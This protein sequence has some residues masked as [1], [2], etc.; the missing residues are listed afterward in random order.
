VK[1]H[2]LEESP[3]FETDMRALTI[4]LAFCL[5]L[6]CGCGSLIRGGTQEIRIDSYPQGA[7]GEVDGMSIQ[8]PAKLMLSRNEAHTVVLRKEG[9]TEYRTEINKEFSWPPFLTDLIFWKL[10]RSKEL[11]AGAWRLTPETINASLEIEEASMEDLLQ[12]ARILIIQSDDD[13]PAAG[14]PGAAPP[15]LFPAVFRVAEPTE[16][17]TA[18]DIAHQSLG[19]LYQGATIVVLESKGNWYRQSCTQFADGW[20][21]KSVV[22]PR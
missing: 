12:R 5:C 13:V 10:F 18:P 11:S 4:P 3:D 6:A 1:P 15:L 22:R 16:V 9:Y 2:V 7:S 21:L 19:T 8:T 14:S 17:F 20:I